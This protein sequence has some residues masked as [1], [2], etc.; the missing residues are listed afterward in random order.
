MLRAAQLLPFAQYYDCLSD[1]TY[2]GEVDKY[3]SGVTTVDEVQKE[4]L[5]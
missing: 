3:L 5:S 2:K 4:C 1:P